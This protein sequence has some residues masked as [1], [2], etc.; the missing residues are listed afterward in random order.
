MVIDKRE[1][2]VKVNM[3]LGMRRITLAKHEFK[4]TKRIYS[5]ISIWIL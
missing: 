3:G 4:R 5:P 1:K 2:N